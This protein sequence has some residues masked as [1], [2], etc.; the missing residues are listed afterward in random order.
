[1]DY[2]GDGLPDS[3]SFPSVEA[4]DVT[5]RGIVG[6]NGIHFQGFRFC[7]AKDASGGCLTYE[8]VIGSVLLGDITVEENSAGLGVGNNGLHMTNAHNVDIQGL[9]LSGL[10]N[11]GVY[12]SDSTLTVTGVSAALSG[13]IDSA[14]GAG[15][16]VKGSTISLKDLDILDAGQS[17]IITDGGE[18]DLDNVTVTNAAAYGMSCAND[19]TINSCDGTFSGTSGDFYTC[20]GACE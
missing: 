17:G 8:D 1:L 19:P 20:A 6:K 18:L 2:D 13:L 5:V 12:V 11:I 16:H 14:G 10:G 7:S 3:Q 15:I 4:N 9:E